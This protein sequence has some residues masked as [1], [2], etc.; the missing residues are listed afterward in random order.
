M[1]NARLLVTGASGQLGRR[2]IAHLLQTHQVAPRRIIA[3][4]RQ[5]A[6]LA[7]LAE[8]GVVV[9]KA[10]F[11]DPASLAA[12]FAGAD[13]LLLIST[14][15][16]DRPGR[17]LEQHRNAIDAAAKAGAKHAVYTSMP[18]PET[19]SPIPFAP[20]HL[21]TEQALAASPMSWTVLRHSWYAENLHLS[22]PGV[23]ASGQWYNAA[24]DGATAYVTREDCARADAAALASDD[25]T[26]T[27]LNITGPAALTVAQIAALATEV[28]GKPVQVV[29]VSAERLAQGMSAAGVPDFLVPLMVSFDL[30][31]AAGRVAGVSDDVL[32]LT[33]QPPQAL[34]DWLAANK[35]AFGAQR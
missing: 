33:G 16:L 8:Q 7:D 11:E 20:D 4:T 17:R 18:R 15:A 6:A 10:D 3:T 5:P 27:T 25:T 35:A 26:R 22:L 9:R 32:R 31:A 14:D 34:K 23:L 29:P 2:V 24:G 21:G 30:N 12:A 13:R 28:L 19:G 1:S